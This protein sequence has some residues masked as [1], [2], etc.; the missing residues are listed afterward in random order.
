MARTRC[1][2]S[3]RPSAARRTS[4]LT[5]CGHLV[6]ERAQLVDDDDEPGHRLVVGSAEPAVVR[7]VA[8]TDLGEEALPAPQLGPQRRQRAVDEVLVEVGDEPHDV[9]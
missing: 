1:T 8:R 9:R 6:D 7:E 3:E 2:P 4:P 5:K